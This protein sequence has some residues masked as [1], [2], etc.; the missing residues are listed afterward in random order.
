M[1]ETNPT[2]AKRIRILQ[3][4]LNK[5]PNAHLD[6]INSVSGKNWD[7]ILVQEPN[8]TF[9]ANI[10][11]PNQFIPVTPASRF[12]L[13]DPVRS[14]IWISSSIS[15][16]TWR[17]I[18]IPNTN[19]ITAVQMTGTFGCLTIFNIYNASEHNDSIIKLH[20]FMG[21]HQE[22]LCSGPNDFVMWNGDFNRHHPLWDNDEDERLFTDNAIVDADFLISRLAEWNMEMVLPKGIPTLK[23]MVTKKYSR[24]D[25]VFCTDNLT[26]YVIKCDTLPRLQPPKT[27]HFPIA[28]TLDLPTE[29]VTR[30]RSRNYRLAEWTSFSEKLFNELADIP[31]AQPI[32]T[33]DQLHKSITDLTQAIQNT[34]KSE[35]PLNDPCPHSKRWYNQ[36]LKEMKKNVGKLSNISWKYRA[37]PD[38]V[39][40]DE[41]RAAKNKYAEEI[42][43]AKEQHWANYLE[44]ATEAQLWTAN[45]YLSEPTGDGGR[46]RI[47]TLKVT[48]GDGQTKEVNTNEEKA[49]VI[50]K[51]FFPDKPDDNLVPPNYN[52]PDPIHLRP[53]F[54][55][56]RIRARIAKL[57]PYKACGPDGIPNIVLQRT[58]NF[59]IDHL[60]HLFQAI[61]ALNVY[62]KHWQEFTTAV[63]RKPGKPNYEV[64]KAYRPIALLCTI[65]KV[66]TGLVAE[67]I[68]HMAEKYELLPDTH[69]GGR[70]G[71]MTTDAIHVL[72]DKI[73]DAWRRKKVVSV[74]FLDIE[75]AFP[76]A[77]NSRLI[78][79]MRKRR[80]P[81]PYTDFVRN[82]LDG[83]STCL[84]FDDYTSEPIQIDNGIG[85][86]DPLSMIAFLFYNADLLDIAELQN[87]SALA[88]VDDSLVA[89]EGDDFE[90]TTSGIQHIMNRE[91]GGFE[92][93]KEH[94]SS[95]EIDKLA[96]MHC[97]N[98]RLRDPA[99]ARKSIP[100]PRPELKLRGRVI[101]EVESYK[102][103]GIMVDSKLR[104]GVQGRRAAAKATNWILMFRRLTRPSTGVSAR[105]MRQLYLTVAIPKMT[106]GLDVWYTPPRLAIGKTRRK[107]SVGALR[108]LEK[109]QR[110]AALAING[111]LRS[112]AGD[113]LD[114]HANLM[115]VD[116]MLEKVCYRGL[117][118]ACTLPDT[119]PLRELV[120]DYSDNPARAQPAP[121]HNLIKIFNVVPQHIET[122]LP[123]TRLPAHRNVFDIEIADNRD[124]SIANE[125]EDDAE[126]KVYVDGS[127]QDDNAGA[128]AVMY[129]K[130][131]AGPE[132]ILHFHLGTL[133]RHTN[134]EAEAVGLLLAM[135]M[136]RNQHVMGRLNVSVYVDSQALLKAIQK[137]AVGPGQYLIEAVIR[138]AEKVN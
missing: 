68:L 105:L 41:Y 73:K 67:D 28:T 115:P 110:I 136:L 53:N 96:V 17:V 7:V 18:N 72:V 109:V 50:S 108:E 40:H 112:T 132:K 59:I 56:E 24:P 45:K 19:D 25:N 98:K 70:P 29:I 8:I 78:H 111:A 125:Q 99:N 51:S 20:S 77:V 106:Y 91:D 21:S 82:L 10:R 58:V 135:W 43:S 26:D 44:E 42:T 89:I 30:E 94:N 79:N 38:H 137:G 92:W 23:H 101:Q 11:T 116:L 131:R 80:I 55:R 100:L 83:R 60:Y 95:F 14:V 15:T 119:H 65:A 120:R 3:I 128:A 5:S 32:L 74:L 54:T 33:K 1:S 122:I 12:T 126:I 13:Q 69:F 121:L 66:L 49:K 123:P 127:G 90:D 129:R 4:N 107:G 104:W 114:A 35:V 88:F 36:D 138:Q 31:P 76:N 63:L 34:I 130:G 85:Q 71:R 46:A 87:E 9:F 133:E 22:Q 81:Q 62:H 61:F 117:V 27:D 113:T 47:P 39:S 57:S 124:D 118:R 134:Y 64:P 84:R 75:G 37:L 103:L 97:T 6:L 2:N 52:Y 102:Y 86:G 93:G 48:H 16:N